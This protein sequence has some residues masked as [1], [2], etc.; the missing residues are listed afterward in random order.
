MYNHIVAGHCVHCNTQ[1]HYYVDVSP[2]TTSSCSTAAFLEL[3][4]Y[5]PVNLGQSLEAVLLAILS[6]PSSSDL[7]LALTVC[8]DVSNGMV[9]MGLKSEEERGERES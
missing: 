3:L 9:P 7:Q 2:V 6:A 5:F 8:H 1:S 4:L